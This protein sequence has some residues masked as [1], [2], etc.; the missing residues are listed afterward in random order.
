MKK[1]KKTPSSQMVEEIVF[2]DRDKEKK[3][4]TAR[5]LRHRLRHS[6]WFTSLSFRLVVLFSALRL[7]R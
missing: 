1:K 6:S 3:E 7:S 4:R 2:F 5:R